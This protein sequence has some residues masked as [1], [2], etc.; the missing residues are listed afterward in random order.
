MIHLY[1]K[2]FDN[3]WK[4][5]TDGIESDAWWMINESSINYSIV[6][7]SGKAAIFESIPY[8]RTDKDIRRH[9]PVLEE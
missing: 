3:L 6:F 2:Q 7:T 9:F 4:R 5:K 8:R 1:T